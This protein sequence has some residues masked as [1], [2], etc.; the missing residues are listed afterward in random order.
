MLRRAQGCNGGT[1]ER[2]LASPLA[3]PRDPP[4]PPVDGLPFCARMGTADNAIART[5]NTT[6]LKQAIPGWLQI[7]TIS[8][9]GILFH[10][11]PE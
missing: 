7:E 8:L 5:E 6:V 9:M 10:E 11:E 4:D 3:G 2:P 1:P